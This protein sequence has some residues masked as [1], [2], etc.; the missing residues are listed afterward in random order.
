MQK[1]K[2]KKEN[3][4]NVDHIQGVMEDMQLRKQRC[5]AIVDVRRLTMLQMAQLFTCEEDASQAVEWLSELLDALLKTHIRLGDD[6]Q[7]TKVFTGKTQNICRC[8]PEYLR[9]WQTAAAGHS[10]TV[11]VSALYFPVLRGHTSSTDQ[12]VEAV[13]S[14]I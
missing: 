11:P 2:K 14:R 1:K 13:Y 5:E 8:C 7:E 6:A 4:E 10:C 9:L 12:S 3:K